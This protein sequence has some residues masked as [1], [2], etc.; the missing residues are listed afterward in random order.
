MIARTPKIT[1]SEIL[2]AAKKNKRKLVID[3]H[4]Q[5]QGFEKLILDVE[6]CKLDSDNDS[7]CCN[8]LR[9][10]IVEICTMQ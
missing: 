9:R 6:V 2:I 5:W 3:H 8:A 4:H 1:P 7:N 10:K